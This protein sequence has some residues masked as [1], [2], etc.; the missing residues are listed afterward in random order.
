MREAMREREILTHLRS[1]QAVL[2]MSGLQAAMQT[3]GKRPCN[4]PQENCKPSKEKIIQEF[5]TEIIE[6]VGVEKGFYGTKQL[7]DGEQT[8]DI[9]AAGEDASLPNM[10]TTG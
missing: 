10:Q 2:R 3:E 6:K 7:P 1:A 4:S 9:D 8:G 5:L